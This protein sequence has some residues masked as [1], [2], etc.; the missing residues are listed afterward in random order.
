MDFDT[1]SRVIVA[2]CLHGAEKVYK[3]AEAWL[4]G[5]RAALAAVGFSDVT[6]EEEAHQ[7]ANVALSW[8]LH[9]R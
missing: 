1:R 5:E 9:Q 6:L 3:A 7:I 4:E 8:S 2:C